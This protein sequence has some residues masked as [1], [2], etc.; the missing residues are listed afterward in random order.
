MRFEDLVVR[1]KIMEESGCIKFTVN[2][3]IILQK[4]KQSGLNKDQI[5]KGLEE[6]EKLEDMATG[7]QCVRLV[8]S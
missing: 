6:I 3:I 4:L 7:T 2:Q 8:F 5:M 1:A